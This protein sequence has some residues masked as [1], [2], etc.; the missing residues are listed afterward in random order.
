MF[1]NRLVLFFVSACKQYIISLVQ[2]CFRV[3]TMNL[4]QH[5]CCYIYPFLSCKVFFATT[6]KT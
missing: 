2:I 6:F 3:K 1:E 4:G 5:R